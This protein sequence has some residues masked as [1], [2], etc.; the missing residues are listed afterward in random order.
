MTSKIRKGTLTK[1][2][3]AQVM[4]G[5]DDLSETPNKNYDRPVI[6]EATASSDPG[7]EPRVPD[8]CT[9]LLIM[10]GATAKW[11]MNYFLVMKGDKRTGVSARG[12]F[13]EWRTALST[14]AG[15]KL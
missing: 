7:S 14:L 13:E 1:Q 4:A 5:Y 12:D 10:A 8:E 9:A 11:N 3:L 6:L 2:T 15:G